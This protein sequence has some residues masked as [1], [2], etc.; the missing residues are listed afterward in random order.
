[1]NHSL[2]HY[3]SR[4]SDMQVRYGRDSRSECL[5]SNDDEL[6]QRV[7]A[8]LNARLREPVHDFQLSRRDDGLVLRGVVKTYYA[9]QVVQ[10]VVMDASGQVVLANDIEVQCGT[11]TQRGKTAAK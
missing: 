3:F 6:V 8:W 1:M 9:K 4:G 7:V 10:E 11:I 5:L 2:Y